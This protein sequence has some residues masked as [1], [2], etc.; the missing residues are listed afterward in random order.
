MATLNTIANRLTPSVPMQITF[1]ASPAA[2]GRKYAILI[3][4]MA[5]SG[6][7]ATPYQVY[8][9]QNVGSASAAY[10]E[11]A[12]LGGTGSQIALMAQ[13]FVN[14]NAV[15]GF[16]NFPAFKV[17]FLPNAE[18]SFGPNG[19]V[20]SALASV[21]ADLLVSCYAAG[22]SANATKL[23]NF[24]QTISGI[25]RD[26]NGQFGSFAVLGSIDAPSVAEGYN[27]NSQYALAACLPDTNTAIVPVIGT[28]TSGSKNLTAISQTAFTPTGT[29]TSGSTTISSVSSVAGIYP[30]ASVTGSNIPAGAYVEQIVGTSL[31]ISAAATNSASGEALVVT[32]LPTAGIYPGA[33]LSGTG[34]P[35]GAT[36]VSV[37]ASALVMS[38]AATTSMSAEAVSVQ[39][40]V[41]QP[42]EIVACDQAALLL[43]SAFPYNPL[44]GVAGGLT[45]PQKSTDWVLFDPSGA[46]EA[47]LAAGLS[48]Y[49]VQSGSKVVLIRTRTTWLMNGLTAVTAYFDWQDLVTLNDFREDVY[50]ISQNPPFNGN[51]GGTKASLQVANLF[52]DEVLR[53]AQSYEDAGAFQ[54]VKSLAPQFIVQPSTTSRGRFDFKIPVNVLPGLFVIAGNIEGVTS[55][56]FTL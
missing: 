15:G 32:N 1:G 33:A 39:N 51:P 54:A 23:I 24:A 28:V 43:G 8:E 38:A 50:H 20:F 31:I 47:M 7:T 3:G 2:T 18:S 22:D 49:S 5:A 19:E 46:S 14:A 4:H 11:V 55:F 13:A 9:V 44:Q 36:V 17:V 48:P 53:E 21:R 26:L 52:K 40:Q 25:D 30:G 42:A 10:D 34:I 16:G 35:A 27:L 41:S 45:P 56:D 6:A 12:A 37:S 29:V